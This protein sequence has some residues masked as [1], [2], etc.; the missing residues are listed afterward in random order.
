[1]QRTA[2][3]LLFL[4]C[5]GDKPPPPPAAPASTPAS[6][7]VVAAHKPP[8]IGPIPG[9]IDPMQDL[10]E[11]NE[12]LRM[13]PLIL[14]ATLAS[15]HAKTLPGYYCAPVENIQG[16]VQ[17]L[18]ITQS[19]LPCKQQRAGEKDERSAIL[20]IADYNA[21]LRL[22]STYEGLA[23]P[24]EK[25]T[26]ISKPVKIGAHAGQIGID[27]KTKI[28]RGS[29][30]IQRRYLVSVQLTDGTEAEVLALLKAENLDGLAALKP[31]KENTIELDD[32]GQAKTEKK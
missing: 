30:V 1:M 26:K 29:V 22:L 10:R 20:T 21:H 31:S 27:E 15:F 9:G 6:K 2:F 17:G 3:F 25:P 8:P 24:T 4:A 16:G 12:D 7:P 28:A 23:K 5:N 13:H 18:V 32:T 11:R 19:V 14:G